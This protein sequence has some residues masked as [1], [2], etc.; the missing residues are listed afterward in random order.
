MSLL[1]FAK[2]ISNNKKIELFNYGNHTRDFTYVDD[3]V[4]GIISIIKKKEIIAEKNNNNHD[5]SSSANGLFQVYNIGSE[6]PI[7]LM[8]YIKLLEKYLGKKAKLKR[9]HYKRGYCWHIFINQ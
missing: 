5:P 4:N 9:L 2:N 3:I 1:K 7:A 6:K 8:K